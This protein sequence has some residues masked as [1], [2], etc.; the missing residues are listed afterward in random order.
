LGENQAPPPD[1]VTTT[2][3][4]CLDGL[5]P[6]LRPGYAELIRRVDLAGESLRTVAR[7]LKITSNNATV[8]LHRARQVLRETLENACGI[9]SKHG[10]LNCVCE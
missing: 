10:C 5:L 1:E 2:I 8:R 6:T 4:T 9:C 7:D 3:C